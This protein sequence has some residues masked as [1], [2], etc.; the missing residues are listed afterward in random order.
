MS[1]KELLERLNYL[2]EDIRKQRELRK[3][4]QKEKE[5]INQKIKE[6]YYELAKK[7]ITKERVDKQWE[8]WVKYCKAN[9]LNIWTGGNYE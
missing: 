4:W 9:N 1:K 6:L 2:K 5:E 3:K 7:G 8:S